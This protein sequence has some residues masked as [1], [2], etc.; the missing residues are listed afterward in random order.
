[1]VEKDFC[2]VREVDERNVTPALVAVAA[3]TVCEEIRGLNKSRGRIMFYFDDIN[4]S[5]K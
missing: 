3:T 1:M 5:R 2:W 4:E